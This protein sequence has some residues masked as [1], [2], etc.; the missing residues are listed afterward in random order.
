M[1]KNILYI[2]M[3]YLM[4]VICD[5]AVADTPFGLPNEINNYS[6]DK[7]QAFIAVKVRGND[8]NIMFV[9]FEN[10][11]IKKLA[12]GNIG[13]FAINKNQ[14]LLAYV[15]N[16]GEKI[17]VI[18]ISDGEKLYKGGRVSQDFLRWSET[19]NQLTFF[20]ERKERLY[21][22]S[23]DGDNLIEKFV[24]ADGEVITVKWNHVC[25]CFDYQFMPSEDSGK[26][27]LYGVYRF[28]DGKLV[29][30]NVKS[31]LVSPNGKYYLLSKSVYETGNFLYVYDSRTD[32]LLKE[33]FSGSQ[34]RG[35]TG[36]IW[37]DNIVRVLGFPSASIN[38]DTGKII[39]SRNNDLTTLDDL[40][41]PQIRTIDDLA[42]DNYGYVLMW[43]LDKNIFEVE[44]IST[45]KIIKTYKKFW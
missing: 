35:Q 42:S 1:K 14:T 21:V 33:Y 44:D 17:V 20:D 27:A 37:K 4:W 41:K 9:D 22:I 15:K 38:I 29:R 6:F 26:S 43:N 28:I 30:K 13:A 8:Y 19:G 24:K 7:N 12:E 39:S 45:G 18:N 11:V 25:R 31:L 36:I 23:F 10:K 16:H 34:V 32:K 3:V 40:N 5:V 2:F